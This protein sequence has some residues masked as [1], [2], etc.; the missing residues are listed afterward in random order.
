MNLLDPRARNLLFF[1]N[2]LF[3]LSLV[4]K[5]NRQDVLLDVL[6]RKEDNKVVGNGLVG[7]I[8]LHFK[9][10]SICFLFRQLHSTRH[11]ETHRDP[12]LS[13][14]SSSLEFQF[15]S[16]FPVG[17][18]CTATATASCTQHARLFICKFQFLYLLPF[19]RNL[20]EW[21]GKEWKRI[22]SHVMLLSSLCLMRWGS[23]FC[24]KQKTFF[25]THICCYHH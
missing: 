14:G 17:S 19:P 10:M 7:K 15:S 11:R 2:F 3:P 12:L 22:G 1:S 18:A 13:L 8:W 21:E 20:G 5:E 9:Q 6:D 4:F 24:L 23:L 16:L 25:V